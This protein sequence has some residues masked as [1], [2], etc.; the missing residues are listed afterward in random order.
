[1]SSSGE[2]WV[3]NVIGRQHFICV[4]WELITEG[5]S[6]RLEDLCSLFLGSSWPLTF[7]FAN[8]SLCSSLINHKHVH[9][10][11][12][13]PSPLCESWNL[14]M[15]WTLTYIRVL[16]HHHPLSSIQV[17][18]CPSLTDLF[19][20]C[21]AFQSDST[22]GAAFS[23]IFSPGYISVYIHI[24]SILHVSWRL[25]DYPTHNYPIHNS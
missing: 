4:W 23:E 5:T 19:A 20:Y 6:S 10:N 18:L 7:S 16:P 9:G 13:S 24:L 14:N 1:M 15:L 11:I 22:S 2:P 8:F 12:W 3:M 21:Q 17:L 25:L